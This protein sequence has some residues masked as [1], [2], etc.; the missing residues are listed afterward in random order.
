MT[1]LSAIAPMAPTGMLRRGFFRSP[2]ILAPAI[3][4]VEAGKNTAKT[5][6][7]PMPAKPVSGEPLNSPHHWMGWLKVSPE[8]LK[9]I[10]T[11]EP[12]ITARITYCTLKAKEALIKAMP[13][14][15]AKAAKSTSMAGRSG[16]T[17]VQPTLAQVH[18]Y[19]QD[20]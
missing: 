20:C 4:P 18:Y 1:R 10:D 19:A 16:N 14:R 5:A 3:M 15:I 2:D 9:P 17:Q 7:K 12:I 13:K 8:M 11:K 6:Q